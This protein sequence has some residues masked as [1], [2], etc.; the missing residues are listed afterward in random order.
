LQF[1]FIALPLHFFL[2]CCLSFMSQQSSYFPPQCHCGFIT[3][4]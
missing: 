3:W 2:I 4:L 1:W